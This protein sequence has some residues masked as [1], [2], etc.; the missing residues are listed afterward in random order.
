MIS[1]SLL[2]VTAFAAAFQAYGGPP[3]APPAP[4]PELRPRRRRRR[5]RPHPRRSWS[6]RPARRAKHSR[7]CRTSTVRYYD[8]AGKNLKGAIKSITEQ[9]PKD[10]SG[11]PITASTNWTIK[12]ELSKR[13]EGTACKIVGARATLV[14]TAE[15][16]RLLD[17]KSFSKKD[18]NAWQA[19]AATLETAAAAKLWFV[20]DHTGDVEKAVLAGTCDSAKA[21]GRRRHRAIAEAIDRAAGAGGSCSSSAPNE[22]TPTVFG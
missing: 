6:F 4:R 14:A 18:L 19:Y 13:T 21:V 12:T 2:A 17:E 7:T 11:Q 10:A 15:L 20:N 22:L 9:R 1:S 5:R 3:P 8:V 16:P